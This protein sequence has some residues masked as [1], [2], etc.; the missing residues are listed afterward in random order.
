MQE[1]SVSLIRLRPSVTVSSQLLLKRG[2][3]KQ[4]L[5]NSQLLS[6]LNIA[7]IQS[8]SVL[9]MALN[10]EVRNSKT[11]TLK[12]GLESSQLSYILLNRTE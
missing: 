3:Q 6:I 1:T 8:H 9:T 5:S 2:M 4:I 7:N 10:T 11:T 12:G